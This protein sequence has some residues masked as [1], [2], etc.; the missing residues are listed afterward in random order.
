[1]LIIFVKKFKFIFFIFHYLYY[2]LLSLQLRLQCLILPIFGHLNSWW[3]LIYL[4]WW[5][6]NW[7]HLF[8]QLI[9]GAV[10][11]RIILI[12]NCCLLY[13]SKI[14]WIKFPVQFVSAL[15][16]FWFYLSNQ[17]SFLLMW[18]CPLAYQVIHLVLVSSN[19]WLSKSFLSLFSH[20]FS[21]VSSILF[22]RSSIQVQCDSTSAF[23]FYLHLQPLYLL[24]L[25]LIH[26]LYH[27]LPILL[28]PQLIHR[29]PSYSFLQ[30]YHHHLHHLQIKVCLHIHYFLHLFLI[31]I[32]PHHL[33][34]LI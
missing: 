3:F 12:T 28:P 10:I 8:H 7:V 20:Q 17:F 15:L 34:M 25:L 32:N 22:W 19:L 2:F 24:L 27:L 16:C 33:F 29:L 4:I 31:I 6:V 13:L 14:I 23:K 5:V 9:F 30:H 21:L 26:P 18:P 1:M 11:S